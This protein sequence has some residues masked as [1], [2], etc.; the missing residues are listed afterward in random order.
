MKQIEVCNYAQVLIEELRD[1]EVHAT[2]KGNLADAF[3]SLSRMIHAGRE[4]EELSAWGD[5]LLLVQ[6][7][8]SEYNELVNALHRVSEA[9]EVHYL[10]SDCSE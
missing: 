2:V 8:L 5:E 4:N 6:S 1:S 9:E 10:L 3:S 7:V